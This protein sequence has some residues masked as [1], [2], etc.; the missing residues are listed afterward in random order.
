MNNK[1]TRTT[2]PRFIAEPSHETA[3]INNND[4]MKKKALCDHHWFLFG[5]LLFKSEI[6]NKIK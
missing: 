1:K 2:K 6:K 4:Y 5:A 3:V